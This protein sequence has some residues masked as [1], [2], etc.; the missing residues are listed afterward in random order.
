MDDKSLSRLFVHVEH[1]SIL[2]TLA[3]RS[4]ADGSPD[5][6]ALTGHSGFR[7]MLHV[8]RI[9]AQSATSTQPRK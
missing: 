8:R 2:R 4:A 5:G 6:P 7:S 1:R 9:D 3:C